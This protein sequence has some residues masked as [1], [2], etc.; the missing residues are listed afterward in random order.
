MSKLIK[1]KSLHN[2]NLKIKEDR[3]AITD[4]KRIKSKTKF[5]DIDQNMAVPTLRI[6]KLN[7]ESSKNKQFV[8]KNIKNQP[9]YT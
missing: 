4:L 6:T 3:N 2:F 8:V 9:K 7:D 5:K 1:M